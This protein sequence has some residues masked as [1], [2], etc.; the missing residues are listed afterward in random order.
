MPTYEYACTNCDHEFERFQSMTDE[1][2][3]RC[4]KCRC[5]IKRLPGSGAGIIFK[6]S[7]FYETDYRRKDTSRPSETPPST[8]EKSKSEEPSKST[9]DKKV[10]AEKKGGEK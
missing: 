5:K 9:G 7:G 8:T 4:P 10:G 2:L 3:K 6:G 1:P